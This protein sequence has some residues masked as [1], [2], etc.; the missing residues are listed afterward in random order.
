MKRIF[1]VLCWILAALIALPL[2]AA[3]VSSCFGYTF[4]ITSIPAYIMVTAFLSVCMVG[5]SIAAEEK[6]ESGT[7]RVLLPFL[8]PLSLVN[9]AFCLFQRGSLWVAVCACIAIGCCLFLTIKHGK[10]LPLTINA[11]GLSAFLL[12]PIGL[13]AF[14]TLIFGNIRQD[15]VVKSVESPSGAYY[16]QVIDSD[17]GAMGGN[18]LVN[19]YESREFNAL[20]FRVSKKPQKVY[21][22]RWGEFEDMDIY[23]KNDKCLVINS[24][25]YEIE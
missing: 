3:L 12:L 21:Q 23:W 8:S 5:F 14:F 13:L 9:G 17:Q 4:E 15:T 7:T 20:V 10:P 6:V 11:L 19:V 24:V 22:G 18:T 2:L 16:A 1:A 25:E